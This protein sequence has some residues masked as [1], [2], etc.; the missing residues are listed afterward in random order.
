M[1]VVGVSLAH[2]NSKGRF[3]RQYDRPTSEQHLIDVPERI[4]G[5][6]RLVVEESHLAQWV[7]HVAEPYV[8]E[9]IICDPRR[10]RWLAEDDFA[11]DKSSARKLA[12]L[13]HSGFIK[14]VRHPDR[15]GAELRSL[16]LH[17]YGLHRQI[18][19]HKNMLKA[20]F[21]RVAICAPGGGIHEP[22]QRHA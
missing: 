21:R 4:R 6:K 2:V 19:R 20:T 10:N 3:C 17:Y 5:P 11:D 7:K 9:L 18:V 12:I 22:S 14:P 13:L 8:D 15:V 16:F 1:A